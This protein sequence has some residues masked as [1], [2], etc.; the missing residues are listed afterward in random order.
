MCAK[1]T[2][3][4]PAAPAAPARPRAARASARKPAP[5][6]PVKAQLAAERR[7]VLE[8]LKP[9]VAMMEGLLGPNVELALHD[10]TQPERSVLAIANGHVSGRQVGSSILSGPKEDRAFAA[11]WNATLDQSQRGHSVVADYPTASPG[12][13]PLKSATVVY[14][15]A[16]GTPFAALCMNA[17][18]S[19]LQLA[20]AWL[21]QV[22]AGKPRA[23]EPAAIPVEAPEMDVL[24][25]DII[26]SAIRTLGKPV[27]LMNKQEKV[28]AVEQM[29]RRGL[30]IVK[31]SVGSA[32]AALGVS[33]FSIYNY[34]DEIRSRDALAQG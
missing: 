28:A 29:L 34:L 32:A 19:V 30:F 31:G 9:I 1:K 25:D 2:S 21:E 23:A 18:L 24:M 6:P 26:A 5:A 11:A 20:H 13:T 15:D 8:V 7:Q 12:G 4:P 17:D 16:E 3:A 22:L 10:L 14:R 33:R 27:R